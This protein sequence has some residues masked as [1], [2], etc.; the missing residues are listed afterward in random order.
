M[1]IE[2]GYYYIENGIIKKEDG[3][4]DTI[5][6]VGRV[7]NIEFEKEIRNKTI[8]EFV[9]K[10]VMEL[11]E[12]KYTREEKFEYDTRTQEKMSS[13]NMGLDKAISIIGRCVE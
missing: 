8:N 10:I 3:Y 4:T 13:Y 1:N 5:Q 2:N 12:E 7:V 9:K 11:K 6:E